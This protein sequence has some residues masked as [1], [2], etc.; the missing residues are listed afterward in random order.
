MEAIVADRFNDALTTFTEPIVQNNCPPKDSLLNNKAFR[1]SLKALLDESNAS[2]ANVSNRR[3]RAGAL[4][5]DKVT[6][7]Y[8]FIRS[9]ED[10]AANNCEVVMEFAFNAS[11]YKLR[12]VAHTH[13]YK[14]F[15]P[16]VR[17]GTAPVPDQKR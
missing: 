6:G 5:Q 4:L 12:A 9:A 2:D 10:P 1:D 7:E 17:C 8:K 11:Q 14:W 3:E 15:E 16:V 13:P